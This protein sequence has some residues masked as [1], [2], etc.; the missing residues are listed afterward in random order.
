[1]PV[2]HPQPNHR[3]RQVLAFAPPYE[4][5][6]T[7]VITATAA[8]S[9]TATRGAGVGVGREGGGFDAQMAGS[10]PMGPSC[11]AKAGCGGTRSSTSPR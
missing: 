2:P 6:G 1:M 11:S 8:R 3:E 4:R 5:D 9:H 10:R 7:S